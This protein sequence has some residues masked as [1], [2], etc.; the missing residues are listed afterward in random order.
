MEVT[1]LAFFLLT[2]TLGCLCELKLANENS[3]VVVKDAANEITMR[4]VCCAQAISFYLL[5]TAAKAAK[6]NKINIANQGL[7]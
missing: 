7:L 1:E 5:C 4:A 2:A 6:Q 3:C